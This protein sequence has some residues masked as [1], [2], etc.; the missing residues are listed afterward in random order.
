M[1]QMSSLEAVFSKSIEHYKKFY[2]YLV[3]KYATS[4]LN[5]GGY[6]ELLKELEEA[7]YMLLLMLVSED[8]ETDMEPKDDI[9]MLYDTLKILV[10]LYDNVQTSIQVSEKVQVGQKTPFD[11]YPIQVEVQESHIQAPRETEKTSISPLTHVQDNGGVLLDKDEEFYNNDDLTS[12][13]GVDL[14]RMGLQYDT[15]RQVMGVPEGLIQDLTNGSYAGQANGLYPEIDSVMESTVSLDQQDGTAGATMGTQSLDT[16]SNGS[17]SELNLEYREKEA[18]ETRRQ[19]V[20]KAKKPTEYGQPSNMMNNME[21]GS[22]GQQPSQVPQIRMQEEVLTGEIDSSIDLNYMVTQGHTQPR[23]QQ[24]RVEPATTS[25]VNVETSQTAAPSISTGIGHV[26]GRSND[27]QQYYGTVEQPATT[28]SQD[29][30]RGSPT[31]RLGTRV[32]NSQIS[33]DSIPM[34]DVT[35]MQLISSALQVNNNG[36]QNGSVNPL[37]PSSPVSSSIQVSKS[38]PLSNHPTLPPPSQSNNPQFRY[39]QTPSAGSSSVS[40]SQQLQPGISNDFSFHLYNSYLQARDTAGNSN[41]YDSLQ[42]Q[43]SSQTQPVQSSYYS[44]VQSQQPSN[45][46]NSQSQSQQQQQQQPQYSGYMSPGG[47]GP[48]RNSLTASLTAQQSQNPSMRE[49]YR[50]SISDS[51]DFT[52]AATASTQQQPNMYSLHSSTSG[53]TNNSR[54]YYGTPQQSPHHSSSASTSSSSQQQSAPQ[55]YYHY[56]QQQ[57]QQQQQE[58]Q[59]LSKSQQMPS[60]QHQQQPRNQYQ[61]LPPLPFSGPNTNSNSSNNP[62][63]NSNSSGSGTT[64]SHYQNYLLDFN[65]SQ[66]GDSDYS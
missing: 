33:T 37:A 62:N 61:H 26:M 12:Q 35:G 25:H 60:R 6:Q 2:E 4:T 22:Q 63:S 41:G 7:I 55:Y 9:N 59:S 65:N 36:V 23:G 46:T 34:Q 47:D 30:I 43:G 52:T 38:V 16:A 1:P 24:H 29:S 10:V 19:N 13:M 17:H 32:M 5:N 50:Q 48:L 42:G 45:S 3:K 20:S 31:Q 14:S 49:Y 18:Q 28:S 51:S 44:S 21:L 66:P 53:N 54:Q 15:D 56:Q 11:I 57:P 8:E 39:V 27:S 64:S 58:Q 40:H